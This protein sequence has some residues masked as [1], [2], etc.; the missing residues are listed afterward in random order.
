MWNCSFNLNFKN[1]FCLSWML[2]ISHF[3][4]CD[5]MISSHVSLTWQKS[6][7]ICWGIVL[8]KKPNIILKLREMNLTFD[9]FY[10]MQFSIKI[11]L[12]QS[13]CLCLSLIKKVLFQTLKSAN[14]VGPRQSANWV[15]PSGFM[16]KLPAADHSG[17][18]AKTKQ[19]SLKKSAHSFVPSARAWMYSC[20]CC[21]AIRA[22]S[23]CSQGRRASAE[24]A[25]DGSESVDAVP[26]S[27]CSVELLE[28]NQKPRVCLKVTS[29]EGLSR[30]N[31][32]WQ[33]L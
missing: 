18:T 22:P 3:F 11:S 5:I 27:S 2:Y 24:T 26:S 13:I 33:L 30:L 14:F 9:R 16:H 12:L 32:T 1:R 20:T 17:Q 4:K 7:E 8:T 21:R 29:L 28:C 19:Q 25:T 15:T 23:L 31:Y 6:F 10:H